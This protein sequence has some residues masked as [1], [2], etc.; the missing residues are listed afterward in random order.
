MNELNFFS[1]DDP[2][3]AQG[4]PENPGDRVRSPIPACV[5]VPGTRHSLRTHHLVKKHKCTINSRGGYRPC[6]RDFIFE[7][8]AFYGC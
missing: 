4:L 6:C 5:V 3:C 2:A 7:S 1:T 8:E